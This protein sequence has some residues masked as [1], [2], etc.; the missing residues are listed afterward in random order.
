M[1]Y[2]IFMDI[3]TSRKVGV[4]NFEKNFIKNLYKFYRIL[5][6]KRCFFV[7]KIEDRNLT[8]KNV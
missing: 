8:E 5:S 4:F 1:K 2:M 6:L 3:E 7:R